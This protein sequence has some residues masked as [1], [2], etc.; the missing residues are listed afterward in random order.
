MKNPDVSLGIDIRPDEFSPVAFIHA[1]GESR[2]VRDKAIR[3]GEVGLRGV[4]SL[5]R[6]CRQSKCGKRQENS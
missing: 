2:P 6:A 5:L 3:I 4:L 1:W